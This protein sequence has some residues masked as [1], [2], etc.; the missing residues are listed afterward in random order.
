MSNLAAAVK[1]FE[2]SR[3]TQVKAAEPAGLDRGAFLDALGKFKVSP[4]QETPEELEAE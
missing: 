2:M 1:W 3:I 4:F